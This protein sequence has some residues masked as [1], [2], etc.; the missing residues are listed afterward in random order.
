MVF[1]V[2][3]SSFPS[4][5]EPPQCSCSNIGS[6]TAPTS[7]L[8][9]QAIDCISLDSN[10]TMA[11]FTKVQYGNMAGIRTTF[12]ALV[13]DNSGSW[14]L[15]DSNNKTLLNS[16]AP[17]SLDTNN[18]GTVQLHVSQAAAAQGGPEPCLGNGIFGP[19]FYYD[20]ADGVLAYAVSPWPYD[21][22]TPGSTYV[23]CYP[24]GFRSSTAKD[25]CASGSIQ[26]NWDIDGG[27][28]SSK[29]PNGLTNQTMEQCCEA[30][31][32]DSDCIAWV[33]SDGT[34]PDSTGENCWPMASVTGL[35][36][37]SGRYYGGAVPPA[38]PSPPPG[39]EGWWI[40]GWEADW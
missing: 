31:N 13:A 17:P 7:Y 30:C 29:Y 10:R 2:I 9:L 40:V 3:R 4:P 21:P 37:Q 11:N 26:Q 32:N 12:G 8:P 38:P 23:H 15:Y 33:W 25:V 35:H 1:L 6:F 14:V 18:Y 34:H 19:P 28:R 16:A 5:Q 24:V 22:N 36:P 39:R 27:D 20:E